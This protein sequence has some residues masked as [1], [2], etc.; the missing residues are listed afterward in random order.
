MIYYLILIFFTM[1]KMCIANL[2]LNFDK[3]FFFLE[4]AAEV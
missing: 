1:K 4:W 2:Y 3:T